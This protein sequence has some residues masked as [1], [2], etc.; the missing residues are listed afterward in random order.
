MEHNLINK[1]PRGKPRGILLI[2]LGYCIKSFDS[3]D[4]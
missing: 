1:Q 3:F 2:N 4:R